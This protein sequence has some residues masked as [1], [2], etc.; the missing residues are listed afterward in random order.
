MQ[1]G[2]L[3]SA[4][5]VI[6]NDKGEFRAACSIPLQTHLSVRA[7]EAMAAVM[8]LQSAR[9]LGFSSVI[10]KMDSKAVVQMINEDKDWYAMQ[11]KQ[12]D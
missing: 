1:N 10:L 7:T 4:G 11:L 6:R 8:G 3:R 5:I 9:D 2:K 12:S